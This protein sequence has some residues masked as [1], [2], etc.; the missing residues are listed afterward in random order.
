M[1][2]S[3]AQSLFLFIPLGRYFWI[4]LVIIRLI[5]HHWIT[6]GMIHPSSSI[7]TLEQNSASS[8]RKQI[9]VSPKNKNKQLIH[10]HSTSLL[11][12]QKPCIFAHYLRTNC[13]RA[14]CLVLTKNRSLWIYS[15]GSKTTVVHLGNM[16]KN[17]TVTLLSQSWKVTFRTA[18]SSAERMY[19]YG[20]STTTSV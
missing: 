17:R 15:N 20:V 9:K 12:M 2:F 4:L 6:L 18:C 14:F 7:Q 5:E 3:L 16:L 8:P 13:T 11:V 19:W 1:L 10:K